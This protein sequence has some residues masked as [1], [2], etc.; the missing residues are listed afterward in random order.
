[1]S[2]VR[3]KILKAWGSGSSSLTFQDSNIR[4]QSVQRIARD[5]LL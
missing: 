3:I 4:L 1:M 2:L 5:S